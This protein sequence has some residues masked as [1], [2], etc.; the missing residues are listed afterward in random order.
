MFR[1]GLGTTLVAI[2]FNPLDIRDRKAEQEVLTGYLKMGVATINEVRKRAGLGK[3]VEGGDR[4][5]VIVGNQ[6]MFVDELTEAMGSELEALTDELER[7]QSDMANK[8]AEEKGRMAGERQ[9]AAVNPPSVSNGN[10]NPSTPNK[11]NGKQPAAA[12]AGS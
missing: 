8:A 1:L 5:F 12:K 3:P 10:G 2:K 4:A 6:I 9:A 7:T 11:A